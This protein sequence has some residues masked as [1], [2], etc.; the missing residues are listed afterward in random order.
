ME[1]LKHVIFSRSEAIDPW[2]KLFT[3]NE[4]SANFTLSTQLK[5]K[6]KRSRDAFE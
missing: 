3:F 2:K 4:K 5:I 1:S 6:C